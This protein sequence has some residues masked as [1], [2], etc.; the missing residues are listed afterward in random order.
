[1]FTVVDQSKEAHVLPCEF[2]LKLVLTH[3]NV[4]LSAGKKGSKKELFRKTTHDECDLLPKGSSAKRN[5]LI[6]QLVTK[7][8][9]SNEENE[10][11]IIEIAVLR[12]ENDKLK[13]KKL[14]KQKAATTRLDK[15]L[16]KL[17]LST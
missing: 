11:M 1:M 7:M 16:A 14:E 12:T 6:T 13:T 8:P 15:I 5:N 2:W 3:F 10:N 4:P 9:R 17:S